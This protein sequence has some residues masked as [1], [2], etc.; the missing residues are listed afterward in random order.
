MGPVGSW[1]WFTNQPMDTVGH[2][3]DH[4]LNHDYDYVH[5]SLV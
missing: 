4:D 5:A 3:Y 1:F 2:P